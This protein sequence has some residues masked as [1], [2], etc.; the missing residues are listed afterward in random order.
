MM[1][2]VMW[3]GRVCMRALWSDRATLLVPP[4]AA[5]KRLRTR[6]ARVWW[7]CVGRTSKLERG[8]L[9]I[10]VIN[11]TPTHGT[12][13]CGCAPCGSRRRDRPFRHSYTNQC[14]HPLSRFAFGVAPPMTAPALR[15][16]FSSTQLRLTCWHLRY[17]RKLSKGFELGAPPHP[18]FPDFQSSM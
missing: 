15:L 6:L 5:H 2:T 3:F 13:G 10:V 4:A 18:P 8:E 11:H 1:R 16:V 9:C 7:R 14:L 12:L 17:K